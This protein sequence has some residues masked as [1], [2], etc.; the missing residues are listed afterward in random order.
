MTPPPLLLPIPGM[1]S[2]LSF[3]QLSR[4]RYFPRF[5]PRFALTHARTTFF[6]PFFVSSP[7]VSASF[8]P[9]NQTTKKTCTKYL[10]YAPTVTATEAAATAPVC[11]LTTALSFMCVFRHRCCSDSA[12][13]VL[14]QRLFIF[15]A[16]SASAACIRRKLAHG[17]AIHTLHANSSKNLL[18]GR[19]SYLQQRLDPTI[20]PLNT[21]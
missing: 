6:S 19:F 20:I 7:V 12:G 11:A 2:F 5:A 10:N 14:F 4:H 21:S 18:H 16:P 1:L 9:N 13:N 15:R 17:P 3:F 8:P